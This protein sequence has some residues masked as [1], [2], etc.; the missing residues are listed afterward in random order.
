MRAFIF[1]LDAFVAFALALVAIYSLIFFSS[2][3]SSYYFLLTQAHY[4]SRDTLLALSTTSCSSY[5][6]ALGCTNPQSSVLENIAFG[7]SSSPRTVADSALSSMIP[8]QFGYILENSSDGGQTWTVI[9]NTPSKQKK[10]VSVSSAV[11]AYG[12]SGVYSKPSASPY[13][14]WSCGDGPGATSASGSGSSSG[15]SSGGGSSGLITCSDSINHDP[16]SSVRSTGT[17]G[18][19]GGAGSGGS[20]G[21]DLVPSANVK[22]LRLTVYV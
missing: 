8:S 13:S 21:G 15:S 14:Y 5:S 11:L 4:L 10:K 20:V 3:P 16:S 19:S 17:G 7:T 18:A 1:S 12:Y 6:S 22:V 9:S 2:V